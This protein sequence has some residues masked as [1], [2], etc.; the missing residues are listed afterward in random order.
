MDEIVLVFKNTQKIKNLFE[1][2][3]RDSIKE[4]SEEF[5]L[6]RELGCDVQ[7]DRAYSGIH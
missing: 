3:I 4:V 5:M 6:R 7:F 2:I 1:K